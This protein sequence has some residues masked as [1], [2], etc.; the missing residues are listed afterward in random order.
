[1]AHLNIAH[2]FGA[3]LAERRRGG[4]ILIGSMGAEIRVPFLAN[5]GTTKAYSP[6]SERSAPLRVQP[7]G[8][9]VTVVPAA[10]E[11]AVLAKLAVRLADHADEADD[12]SSVYPRALTHCGKTGPESF[13]VD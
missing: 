2:R 11:P 9:Y 4:L 10:D 6:R 7:G 3:K 13:R 12:V 8:V 5:D 1:M